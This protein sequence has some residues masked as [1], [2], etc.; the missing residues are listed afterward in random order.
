MNKGLRLAALLVFV[1]GSALVAEQN[2]PAQPPAQPPPQARS[3]E[4][5][6]ALAVIKETTALPLHA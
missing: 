1:T 4:R 3:T 6:I 5:S 2:P